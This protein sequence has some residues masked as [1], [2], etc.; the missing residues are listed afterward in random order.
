M[1]E[2]VGP[3][4]PSCV[5]FMDPTVDPF[6]HV[7]QR[8]LVRGTADPWLSRG[9]WSTLMQWNETNLRTSSG[10]AVKF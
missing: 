2:T 9:A 7:R 3:V 8:P 4:V 6:D 1:R 5:L 10:D